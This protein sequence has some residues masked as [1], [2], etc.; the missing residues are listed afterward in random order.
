MALVRPTPVHASA[1][2]MRMVDRM[3]ERGGLATS[4]STKAA[5]A[6]A[7]VATAIKKS[8]HGCAGTDDAIGKGGGAAGGDGA[9]GV[10]KM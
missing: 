2:T 7:T 9:G 1:P 4:T 6:V 10:A 3:K 5:A 8:E